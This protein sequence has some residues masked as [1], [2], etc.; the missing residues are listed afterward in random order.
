MKIRSLHHVS[1]TVTDIEKTHQFAQDFGLRTVEKSDDHFVMQTGGG[2]AW[3]YKA[4]KGERGFSGL[5][6]LVESQSD[7]QEAIDKHGATEIR[8]LDTPGGGVA[9]TL[10]SPEGIKVDLVHGI[11]GDTP[12]E[13]QPE[14]RL[15]SPASRTRFAVPQET[16][17]LGPASLYRLGHMGLFV[18]DYKK[19]AEWLEQT[20]GLICTD[21]MHIPGMPQKTVVGFFRID[22]GSEWVDHH[23]IFLAEDER[24]DLHHISF[25]A[26]DYEAQ[27]RAHRWLLKQGYDLNWGVG[28]HPLGSHVFD[29]WFAPD[30]YRFETFTDTDLVNSDHVHG[31][32]DISQH[33]MDCWSDDPA[34]K[35]F[36]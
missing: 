4:V 22:R 30:R 19:N 26:Q 13:V 25:E 11:K 9:V 35:Y 8:N 27:F 29:V 15:N 16:R 20:L 23:A 24:S 12:A 28:R 5:G 2:D 1:F 36:A 18:N 3:C 21:S 31:H 17:P 6:F 10:T 32:H 7:L 34:E 14:L 33:E